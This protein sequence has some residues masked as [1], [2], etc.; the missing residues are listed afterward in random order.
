M[1]VREEGEMADEERADMEREDGQR[2]SGKMEKGGK[3]KRGGGARAVGVINLNMCATQQYIRG[4]SC[5]ITQSGHTWKHRS[6]ASTTNPLHSFQLFHE[7]FVPSLSPYIYKI[8]RTSDRSN[9]I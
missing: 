2:E 5:K 7:H 1:C 6:I 9:N 8:N 4:I 3:S